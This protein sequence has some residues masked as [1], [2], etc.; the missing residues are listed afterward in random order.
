M[1]TI[2]ITL[3][4]SISSS[5]SAAAG[6]SEMLLAQLKS[7]DSALR[8][9]AMEKLTDC[10]S[11]PQQL[12][13]QLYVFLKDKDPNLRARA[14]LLLATRVRA[15][16]AMQ[17]AL[18]VMLDKNQVCRQAA[19]EIFYE[20]RG[21]TVPV[22][23][24]L[25][26]HQ[27]T[28]VVK[29]ALEVLADQGLKAA[30]ALDQLRLLASYAPPQIMESARKALQKLEAS[31]AENADQLREQLKNGRLE[32]KKQALQL[33]IMGGDAFQFLLPDAAALLPGNN[34]ELN[35]LLIEFLSGHGRW[36]HRYL[37]ALKNAL[38]SPDDQ[39]SLEAEKALLKIFLLDAVN[40]ENISPALNEQL[41]QN[42]WK[43]DAA[44]KKMTVKHSNTKREELQFDK[45][46]PTQAVYVD[47]DRER[48][49]NW[50]YNEAG[51]P[52]TRTLKTAAGR[53]LETTYY[54]Y[55]DSQLISQ[56]TRDSDEALLEKIEYQRVARNQDH[57]ADQELARKAAT[58]FLEKGEAVQAWVQQRSRFEDP[59]RPV[60]TDIRLLDA[61][62]NTLEH[63]VYLEGD[64]N[65]GAQNDLFAVG[66][67][68]AGLQM[69]F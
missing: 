40:L 59:L 63:R 12:I 24:E 5:L 9:Q 30:P 64:A 66:A 14:A 44:V 19:L 36:A 62:G 39:V 37:A 54:R 6:C 33:A 28:R 4:I 13:N 16:D 52:V 18:T 56:E 21:E 61:Q 35:L 60:R 58:I 42:P 50:I 53:M 31:A 57:T 51:Q 46:K 25:M 67:R 49:E 2:I 17:L 3:L 38:Y 43:A 26:Q 27:E 48:I 15:R 47:N 32:Q 34:I 68:L 7:T 10:Q 8:L 55:Q 22:L 41:E 45:G 23:Q 65:A 69:A 1:K 20:I 29:A 11:D